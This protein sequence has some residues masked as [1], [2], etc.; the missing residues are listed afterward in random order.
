MASDQTTRF[1]TLNFEIFF[2]KFSP[3]TGSSCG[4]EFD[5]SAS[6]RRTLKFFRFDFSQKI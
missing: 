3:A 5:G 2:E 6:A 1:R 4:R